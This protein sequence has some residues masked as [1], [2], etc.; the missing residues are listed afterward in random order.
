MPPF[1][2]DT[3]TWCIHPH[4]RNVLEGMYNSVLMMRD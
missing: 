4:G 2:N 1:G 3:V